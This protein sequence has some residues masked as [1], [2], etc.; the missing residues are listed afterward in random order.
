MQ[1]LDLTVLTLRLDTC[2]SDGVGF[3]EFMRLLPKRYPGFRLALDKAANELTMPGDELPPLLSSKWVDPVVHIIFLDGT[4]ITLDHFST[5]HPEK[6]FRI[7]KF[8]PG[9]H[10]VRYCLNN[11]RTDLVL[12]LIDMPTKPPTFLW[13]IADRNQ[14]G[15]YK[16]PLGTFYSKF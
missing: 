11:L 8:E 13:H 14:E 5:M 1:F 2:N 4:A 12:A 9:T 7:A 3:V 16:V 10:V 6:P 15:R